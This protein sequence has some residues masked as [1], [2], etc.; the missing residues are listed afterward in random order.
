[1][2]VCLNTRMSQKFCNIL[3]CTSLCCI[4]HMNEA[5]QAMIGCI[6]VLGVLIRCALITLYMI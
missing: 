6:V 2:L 4:Y 5:V 3:L 1:M